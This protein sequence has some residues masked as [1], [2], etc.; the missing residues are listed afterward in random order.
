MTGSTSEQRQGSLKHVPDIR[1]TLKMYD[2]VFQCKEKVVLKHIP[3]ITYTL[4]IYDIIFHY[5]ENFV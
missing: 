1:Y 4:K 5:K 3:D 2:I